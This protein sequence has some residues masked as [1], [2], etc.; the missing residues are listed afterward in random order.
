MQTAG[1]G[2]LLMRHNNREISDQGL[3]DAVI[4]SSPIMRL[5]MSL[6]DHPYLVPL[7]FGYDGAT[8]FFHTGMKGRKVEFLSV[9]PLVCFEFEGSMRPLPDDN[10]G[11]KWSFVYRTV[12]GTGKAR[13]LQT[14]EERIAGLEQIMLQYSGSGKWTFDQTALALT[15]VWQI[16]IES[17]TGRQSKHGWD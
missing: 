7:C 8:L 9:N 12:I 5:A 1:K 17:L 13:E 10:L 15:R 14:P 4:R 3:V 16:H 11:C 6:K 2:A